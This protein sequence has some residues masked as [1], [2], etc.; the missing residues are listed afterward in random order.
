MMILYNVTVKVSRE[1][2]DDWREW[3][4]ARHIPDV[5]ATGMFTEYKF[6]RLLGVDEDDGPTYAIQYLAPNMEAYQIY[7]HH[8]A[9]RLQA[10]HQDSYQDRTLA[11][12]TLMRVVDQG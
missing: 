10:E 8:F 4:L 1:V 5:M 12:R 6:A 2:H 7:Q 11:F 9:P 3:M